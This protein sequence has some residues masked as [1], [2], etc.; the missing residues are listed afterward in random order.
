MRVIMGGVGARFI[1]P[2]GGEGIP[3][4]SMNLLTG[5]IRILLSFICDA[6]IV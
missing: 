5:I 1:A 3:H 6:R 4:V 2:W